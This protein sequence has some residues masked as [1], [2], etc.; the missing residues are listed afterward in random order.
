[1]VFLTIFNNFKLFLLVVCRISP[2]LFNAI[3][4][5]NEVA[6][7]IQRNILFLSLSLILDLLFLIKEIFNCE[8]NLDFY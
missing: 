4:I 3:I 7:Q 8:K 5:F 6:L 1:M 2:F